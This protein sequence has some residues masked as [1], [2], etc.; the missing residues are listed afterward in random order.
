LPNGWMTYPLWGG[1]REGSMSNGL[2]YG[3]VYTYTRAGDLRWVDIIALTDVNQT[4]EPRPDI[5]AYTVGHDSGL[6]EG[7]PCTH[8][9][10]DAAAPGSEE[11]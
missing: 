2:G 10:W 4:F 6:I 3:Q 5:F 11:R 7:C 9:T 1:T 8:H